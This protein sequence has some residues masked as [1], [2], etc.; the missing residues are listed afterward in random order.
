MKLALKRMMHALAVARPVE[1]MDLAGSDEEERVV[2]DGIIDKID[3]VDAVAAA[4]PDDLII[5]MGMDCSR[6]TANGKRRHEVQLKLQLRIV[7]QS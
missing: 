5:G 1:G 7:R 3:L 2:I 6:Q 4:K